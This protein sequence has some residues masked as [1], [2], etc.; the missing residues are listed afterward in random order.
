MPLFTTS[1][2]YDR[3]TNPLRDGV[4]EESFTLE[5]GCLAIPTRP[6]LGVRLDLDFV[7][8]HGI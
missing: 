7:K 8:R 1:N 3:S 2:E 4:T 5:D 6:G